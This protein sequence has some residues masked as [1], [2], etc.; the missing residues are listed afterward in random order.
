MERL[1]WLRVMLAFASVVCFVIGVT[2]HGYFFSAPNP[3]PTPV[4]VQS[5]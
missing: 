4:V 1:A 2:L 3:R 5:Q